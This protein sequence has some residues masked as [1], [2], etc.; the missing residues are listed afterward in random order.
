MAHQQSASYRDRYIT[1]NYPNILTANAFN[2]DRLSSN[3]GYEFVY[4]YGSIMHYGEYAF[5][6]DSNYKTIDC[7]GNRCG[8]R[9]GLSYWDVWEIFYYNRGYYALNTG[10]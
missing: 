3:H 2:F 1:V 9:D 8:Q 5:A 10:L 6:K 4:D 7:R